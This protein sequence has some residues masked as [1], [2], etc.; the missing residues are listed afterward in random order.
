METTL[1]DY[2]SIVGM[3]LEILFTAVLG[4]GL[5]LGRRG[6]AAIESKT[7]IQLDDQMKARV[8]DAIV[9]AVNYAKSQVKEMG[10]AKLKFDAKYTAVAMASQYV[11]KSVPKALD[12]FDITQDDLMDKI[13]ARLGIDLDLDGDIGGKPVKDPFKISP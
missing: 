7:G 13:E 6:I 12:Y 8:D 4:G 1:V 3:V 11:I 2:S 10:D 5:F 9:H